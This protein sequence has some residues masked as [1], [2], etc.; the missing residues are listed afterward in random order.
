MTIASKHLLDLASEVEK[1]ES[2]MTTVMEELSSDFGTVAEA[3]PGRI[4]KNLQKSGRWTDHFSRV[5]LLYPLLIS[6]GVTEIDR[7]AARACCVAQ[8]LL[9][10]PRFHRRP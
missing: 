3:M 5:T 6:E 4:G 9:V 1:Y 7:D 2:A 8:T 10:L